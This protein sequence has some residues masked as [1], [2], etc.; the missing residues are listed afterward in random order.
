MDVWAW[1]EPYYWAV[2]P[3]SLLTS[4][5][6]VASAA[7]ARSQAPRVAL[8]PVLNLSG[9]KWEELKARQISK[10]NEFLRTE[11]AKRGFS[12]VPDAELTQAIGELKIDFTDE[13]QQKRSTLFELGKKLNADYIL[14]GVITATEQKKQDR[15]FY[16]DVEGRADVK[17]WFLDVRGE[18][19]LLSAKT[20]TGRSGG[21][22][23]SFDNKGS[24]RQV[25]ASANA[26]RDALKEFFL[27]HPAK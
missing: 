4:I 1:H 16:K 3:T 20:V 5:L 21:N 25:Q 17:V 27:A 7:V 11:F 12:V 10:S 8:V 15:A 6:L 22:R 2:R 23:M 13:E 24:D 18:K 26:F 19:P 9:E 14:F